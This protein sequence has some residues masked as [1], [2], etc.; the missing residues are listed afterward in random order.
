MSYAL[1]G[2]LPNRRAG[3][4]ERSK[5]ERSSA[6]PPAAAGPL[7]CLKRSETITYYERSCI[8]NTPPVARGSTASPGRSWWA[9]SCATAR[10]TLHPSCLT[11]PSADDRPHCLNQQPVLDGLDA[12]VKAR[13][14]V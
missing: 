1:C 7:G 8:A 11:T 4:A 9:I 12:A 3:A 6:P 2:V 14:V 13:F 10:Y 5:A